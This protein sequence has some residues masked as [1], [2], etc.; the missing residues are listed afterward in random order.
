MPKACQS[1]AVYLQHSMSEVRQWPIWTFALAN[2][3]IQA[4]N[5]VRT[6]QS[7]SFGRQMHVHRSTSWHGDHKNPI[8]L[9]LK[10]QLQHLWFALV[11]NIVAC[12]CNMRQLPGLMNLMNLM[13]F[14]INRSNRSPKT[15]FLPRP[16]QTGQPDCSLPTENDARVS[17]NI[18]DRTFQNP[19]VSP[20]NGM[21]WHD[22]AETA[23]PWN[24][25]AKSS[26]KC[27]SKAQNLP[28]QS[29][30]QNHRSSPCCHQTSP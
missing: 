4:F 23:P 20:K 6:L 26:A 22:M 27:P 9:Q 2:S 30:A 15:D 24:L 1:I 19:T 8:P 7:L 17:S 29:Q 5:L 16:P 25:V 12:G 14:H 28:R 11:W 21:T 18:I 3:T 10:Q 13:N